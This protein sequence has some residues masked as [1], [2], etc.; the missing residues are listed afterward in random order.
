VLLP[1]SF[2]L[3]AIVFMRDAP[4]PGDG[5]TVSL[6]QLSEPSAAFAKK[7]GGAYSR[8]GFSP[9]WDPRFLVTCLS[10]GGGLGSREGDLAWDAAGLASA[11]GE[12]ASWSTGVNGS[13]AKEDD[14]QFKYLF[15][16]P[17]R[18]LKEGRTLYEYMDSSE[19]FVVPEDRRAELDF[20]W[21]ACDGRVPVSDGAVYAGIIRGAP[22]R[23]AAE[24]FLR[25]LLRPDSQRAVLERA[26]G[27]RAAGYSFGF[28][29]GFSSI[30]SVNEEVFPAFYPALVGHA[31]P[32]ASLSAPAELPRDW[33][34]IEAAVFEP[35]AL[36]AEARASVRAPSALVDE[37]AARL[38]DYRK[39]GA[40]Q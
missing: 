28:A 11:L 25:W 4:A 38:A 8:M 23:G 15:A 14:F 31:P 27:A 35:W 21:L 5:F 26:R 3:P 2:N 10:R 30:R 29:G 1:L 9:R 40:R 19:L 20:R 33:P 12:L 32:A 24:A 16:P 36:E 18:R 37:L 7:E 17:Y 34:S 13:A 6:G 39:R 22:G